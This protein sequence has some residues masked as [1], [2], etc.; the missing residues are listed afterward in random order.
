MEKKGLGDKIAGIMSW[1]VNKGI[2]KSSEYG[3]IGYDYSKKGVKK[4]YE[5]SKEKAKAGAEYTKEVI[6]PTTKKYVKIGL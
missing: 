2:D 5:Y 3:K 6:Y 4:G 1:A